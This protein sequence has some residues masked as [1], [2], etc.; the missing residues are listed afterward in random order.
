M[1]SA[2]LRELVEE[3]RG[4]MRRAGRRSPLRLASVG[5][6]GFTVLHVEGWSATVYVPSD[7]LMFVHVDG[8]V[9]VYEVEGRPAGI[10][11]DLMWDGSLLTH[12]LLYTQPSWFIE[13]EEYKM[14][15]REKYGLAGLARPR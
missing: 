7:E 9:L 14:E 13:P 8:G 5:D 11:A 2:F 12:L 15:L 4:R 1:K 10:Y 3:L 6:Y